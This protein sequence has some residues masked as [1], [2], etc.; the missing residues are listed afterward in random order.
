MTPSIPFLEPSL[1][2]R[3]QGALVG[4]LWG[5][6]LADRSRLAYHLGQAVEAAIDGDAPPIALA[7]AVP[8]VEAMALS[9]PSALLSFGESPGEADDLFTAIVA[10]HGDRQV[11]ELWRRLL[12]QGLGGQSPTSWIRTVLGTASRNPTLPPALHSSLDALGVV[13]PFRQPLGRVLDRIQAQPELTIAERSLVQAIG[14]GRELQGQ[15]SLLDRYSHGQRRHLEAASRPLLFSVM[16]T[17]GRSEEARLDRL[18]DPLG[19]DAQGWG[20][21]LLRSWAGILDH[22]PSGEPRWSPNQPPNPTGIP[23]VTSGIQ[24]IRL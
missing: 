6:D 15:M 22:R 7:P 3:F 4:L 21:S 17:A 14:L 11:L 2:S 20:E 1:L 9:L 10:D 13:P 24:A 18:G 5:A 8:L 16:G 12:L 19:L 23:T